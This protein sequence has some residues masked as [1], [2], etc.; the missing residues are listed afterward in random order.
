M[1]VAKQLNQTQAFEHAYSTSTSLVDTRYFASNV[2]IVCQQL[3]CKCS[4]I[5][6]PKENMSAY[7][8][9][10]PIRPLLFLIG[11][12]A[13]LLPLIKN[14]K[15][16]KLLYRITPIRYKCWKQLRQ[17]QSQTALLNKAIE[18]QL[19]IALKSI[20]KIEFHSFNFKVHLTE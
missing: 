6:D 13:D 8:I 20:N 4:N 5:T 12:F 18:K 9:T 17:A 1:K 7:N 11:K 14:Q 19:L 16:Y 15:T 2:Y 10:T 3:I